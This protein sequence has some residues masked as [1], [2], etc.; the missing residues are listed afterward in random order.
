VS[1][2]QDKG[3]M[4]KISVFNTN[5]ALLGGIT[6]F[7]VLDLGLGYTYPIQKNEP[8]QLKGFIIGLTARLTRNNAIYG[9]LKLF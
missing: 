3:L 8:I 5:A 7:N 4:A 9:K 6:I 2:N 1:Y